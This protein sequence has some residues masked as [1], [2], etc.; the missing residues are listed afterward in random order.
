MP[1]LRARI[2]IAKTTVM[3]SMDRAATGLSAF[4]ANHHVGIRDP[5]LQINLRN[6]LCNTYIYSVFIFPL[7]NPNLKTNIPLP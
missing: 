7:E 6:P 3:D 4:P 2:G 5:V 1:R